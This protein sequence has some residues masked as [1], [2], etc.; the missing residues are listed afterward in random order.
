MTRTPQDVFLLCVRSSAS[1]SFSSRPP[2]AALPV[3]VAPG[4]PCP[5]LVM[6]PPPWHRVSFPAFNSISHSSVLLAPLH[7][8]IPFAIGIA[9]GPSSWAWP[10]FRVCFLCVADPGMSWVPPRPPC[11][12]LGPHGSGVFLYRVRSSTSVSLCD[13]RCFSPFPWRRAW[14]PRAERFSLCPSAESF[15]P[16]V[17][18]PLHLLRQCTRPPTSQV[19][20]LAN[21][22]G[23]VFS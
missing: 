3:G 13:W 11:D 22:F 21:P 4:P 6:R 12:S 5:G 15:P 23:V 2:M 8:H 1:T 7:G 17:G 19:V 16:P 18:G 10:F 20:S 14:P 9:L